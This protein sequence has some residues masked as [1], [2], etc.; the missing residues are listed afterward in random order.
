VIL[1]D[2]NIIIDHLRGKNGATEYLEDLENS[3]VA[4]SVVTEAELISGEECSDPDKRTLVLQLLNSWEK[5]EVD[6]EIAVK[7]GDLRREKAIG[8]ADSII[9]ATALK[10]D[11][12]LATQNRSDFQPVEGLEVRSPY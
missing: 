11:A 6:N 8:I 3:E 12:R 1:V 4:F 10:I 2:T 7:A 5:T 9:A